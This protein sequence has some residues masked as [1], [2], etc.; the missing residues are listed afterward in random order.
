[1]IDVT[2]KLNTLI[3]MF[4]LCEK[5]ILRNS[6]EENYVESIMVVRI[7]E[8]NSNVRIQWI[9]IIEYFDNIIKIVG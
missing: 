3:D 1:M 4:E 7:F 2:Q 5:R 9:Q 6:F 8:Y